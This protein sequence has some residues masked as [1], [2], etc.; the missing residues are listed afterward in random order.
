GIRMIIDFRSDR[1]LVNY[2]TPPIAT[3]QETKRIIIL[4]SARDK[5]EHMLREK[6]ASGIEMILVLDYRRIIKNHQDDFREF[7]RILATT[8]QLPL[9]YHCAAGKDRTGLATYL[10][11]IALGVSAEIARDDYLLSNIYLKPVAERYI[12]E[13]EEAGNPNGEILRPLLEVREAYLD[14][15]INEIGQHFGTVERFL[16]DGLHADLPAL[17]RRY[18]T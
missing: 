17:R 16:T 11:L 2:P 8:D 5:A 7:F 14:A 10:L 6:N 15:A 12:R 4:D 9:M 18:L 1:E 3:V 13:A